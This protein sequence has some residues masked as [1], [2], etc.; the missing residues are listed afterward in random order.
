MAFQLPTDLINQVQIAA[1]NAAGLNAY[2]PDDPSLPS[3]PSF[4]ASV[5]AVDPSAPEHLRCKNCKA[6][7]LRGEDSVICIYCGK[8]QI[9]KDLPPH[10]ISFTSTFGYQWLLRS[11]DLDQ[12]ETVGPS[13]VEHG[14][15]RGHTTL[16]QETSLRHL[17]DL[18]I[19]WPDE[20]EIPEISIP[21]KRSEES[22]TFLHLSGADLDNVYLGSKGNIDT[23]ASAQQITEQQLEG[24][25]SKGSISGFGSVQENI[26][27]FSDAH[28]ADSAVKSFEDNQGES[29]S[30]WAAD[31]QSAN[32]EES[33]KSYD[34]FVAPNIDLSSHIDSV[35]GAG[36]DVNRRKLSDDLQ[37]AQSASHDWMQDDIWKNVDSKVSQQASHFS[38]TA[39]T[40]IAV[41]PDNYK[42]TASEGVDWFEDD[43]RQKNITSEPGNKIIDNPDDSFDDWN[44]FASSSNAVNLSGDEPSSKVIDK[45]D[46]SF[47]DWNDF[48]SSSNIAN[49]SGGEPSNKVIDKPDDA[50]D[51][52]NDF[53]SS[54]DAVNISSDKPSNKI[55]DRPDD[56]FNGW[57]EFAG[58][59]ND[60]N[61]SGNEPRSKTI[62]KFDDSFDDWNDF[63]ST[64]N[65]LDLSGNALRNSNHQK[66]VS[67]EQTSEKN[68]FSSTGNT[69]D[70]ELGSF[71]QPN[72]F[73]ALPGGY[74]GDAVT[75]NI[76]KEV[77]ASERNNNEQSHVKELPEDT[78][79]PPS[80]ESES[81]RGH[82]APNQ[83]TSSH[84]L[85]DL[86]MTGPDELKM[87][88][89]SVPPETSEQSSSSFDLSGADLDSVF[90]GS[91]TNVH[92]DSSTQPITEKQLNSVENKG[93]ISGFGSA[94]DDFTL[95]SNDHSADS[96]VKSFKDSRGDSFSGWPADFQ[97]ANKDGSSKS[98]DPFAAC[99]IDL[100][101]HIDSVFG[102]RKDENRG[103]LEDDLQHTQYVSD[104]WMRGDL[105]KNLDSDVS[106]HSVPLGVTAEATDGISQNN[107]KNPASQ[108]V[109][110]FIDNQ[111]HK[112]ITNVVSIWQT[113]EINLVSSAGSIQDN[114]CGSFSHPN[115][116]SIFHDVRD[117]DA[118]INNVL[119]EVYALKSVL[120]AAHLP[121][122]SHTFSWRRTF[123]LQLWCTSFV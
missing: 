27:S 11:L 99:N 75:D 79:E 115:F 82:I 23:D 70:D 35:F 81:N 51:D 43:Q 8:Q 97:S 13:T 1:R 45:L 44:D 42:N 25:E 100:S 84:H 20:L 87:P 107:A 57:N 88:D 18:Q 30:G 16:Y 48:A 63:A 52:W 119:S 92:S 111:W 77:Y 4:D 47:D 112:D 110:W 22:S 61:H 60:V 103:R 37:P 105:W 68:L 93:S 72:L 32:K 90:L 26:T 121:K 78:A 80:V 114:E 50:F 9:N 34:S 117:G 15:S 55:I 28:S 96:A 19:T 76:H 49:L 94:Q 122:L 116:F 56:S 109:D 2:N 10:P 118:M 54:S 6:K 7:L 69:Q 41:S 120:K 95:F 101:S 40:T 86:Q 74:D 46:E 24:V 91:K 102:A 64:S 39:E 31:F 89:A 65:Y 71:S 3:L 62:D 108:G 104:D 12:S 29:L 58:S 36:K 21:H 123:R 98:Y 59:S 66:A 73:S 53:A 5:F 17:L 106:Q 113:F 14:S 33:S 85:Y 83:E 67:S 38:S